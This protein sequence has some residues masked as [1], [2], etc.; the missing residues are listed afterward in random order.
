MEC[1]SWLRPAF[2]SCRFPQGRACSCGPRR[3]ALPLWLRRGGDGHHHPDRRA[4][5]DVSRYPATT[6]AKLADPDPIDGLACGSRAREG[7][8]RSGVHLR[9][10]VVDVAVIGEGK[11]SRNVQM[12][13]AAPAHFFEQRCASRRFFGLTLLWVY[14]RRHIGSAHGPTPI[15]S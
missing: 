14:Y 15:G 9:R 2:L 8:R 6:L 11:K 1:E 7:A 12:I 10:R 4:I 5:G 13:R 3:E